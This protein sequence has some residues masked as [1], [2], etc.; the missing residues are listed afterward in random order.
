[1]KPPIKALLLAA[2]FGTRL[3]PLTIKTPKCLVEVNDKPMLEHWLQHLEKL[4]VREVIINTHYLF[5]KVREFI[6][7]RDQSGITIE[8]FYEHKLLGTAGTLL[9]NKD[10]FKNST[11]LLIHADNYTKA[12][13]SGLI[14]AHYKKPPECLITMLTFNAKEP[15]LCG[16]VEINERNIVTKFHEKVENPPSNRANGAIYVFDDIFIE[17]L[18]QTETKPIDFSTQVLPLMIGKI[19]TWHLEEDYF[20]IGTFSSLNRAQLI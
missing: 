9:K 2:G 17:W 14:E 6:N 16:I 3:R 19:Y 8:E 15:K 10:F 20:D 18:I 1:M 13:L 4:S 12:D 11:G 5:K 7:L